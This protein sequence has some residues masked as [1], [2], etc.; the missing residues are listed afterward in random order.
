M[1]IN[2]GIFMFVLLLNALIITAVFQV[3]FPQI[4]ML[5]V[6]IFLYVI[7]SVYLWSRSAIFEWGVL[8]ALALGALIISSVFWL[9]QRRYRKVLK[10]QK[11]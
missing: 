1:V 8:S 11:I 4:N 7:T 3:F 10:K 5:Y 2:F 6:F 9:S